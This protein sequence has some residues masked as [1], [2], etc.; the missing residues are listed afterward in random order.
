MR[1][2]LLYKNEKAWE[3]EGGAQIWRE[4]TKGQN[5]FVQFIYHLFGIFGS[6]SVTTQLNLFDLCEETYS[7]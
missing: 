2:R 1:A 7:P 4:I 5:L 6:C 3:G